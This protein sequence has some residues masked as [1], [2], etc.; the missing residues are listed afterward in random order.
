MR[1]KC[2]FDRIANIP[3]ETEEETKNRIAQYE[4]RQ[5]E[6]KKREEE[7]LKESSIVDGIPGRCVV[8][9]RGKDNDMFMDQELFDMWQNDKE[10][11]LYHYNDLEILSGS[12]GYV[13]VLSNG[14]KYTQITLIS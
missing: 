13:L 8:I 12:C 14:K 1:Y 6:A 3:P 2:H 11:T 10:S 4:K 5:L 7:W 9:E